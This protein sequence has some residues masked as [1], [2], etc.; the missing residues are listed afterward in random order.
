M[1]PPEIVQFLRET[2]Q[3]NFCIVC[4]KCAKFHFV[5]LLCEQTRK[6]SELKQML[7]DSGVFHSFKFDEQSI[8]RN[9]K[10]KDI[11]HN[12]NNQ[13]INWSQVNISR[14]PSSLLGPTSRPAKA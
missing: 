10:S 7:R 8:N 9:E 2:N 5:V 1:L 3:I 14:Q 4:M 6:L 12:N 11:T 13:I